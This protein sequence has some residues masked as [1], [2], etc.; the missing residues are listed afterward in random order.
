MVSSNE[1][2]LKSIWKNLGKKI[3]ERENGK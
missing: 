1:E 2:R 3:K